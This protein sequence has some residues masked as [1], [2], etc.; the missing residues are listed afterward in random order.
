MAEGRIVRIGGASA[1]IGDGTMATPQL[2]GS[3]AIDYV[4]LDYLSEYFMPIAGRTRRQNPQA[5]YVSYFPDELFAA[6]LPDML[7]N[8]VRMVTNAGAVNP[9]A[10][11]AAMQAA[12][13]KLGFSPKIAV[14]DG[15]DLLD[16]AGQFRSA[17][18][19]REPLPPNGYT[20][21]NAYV[22]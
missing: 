12:A 3:G 21:I 19:L 22:G 7:A 5:G 16:R 18:Q 13:A 14:V 9:R 6:V 2:I 10:C 1:G 8:K 11:G 17:G 20:G 15:D 4:M